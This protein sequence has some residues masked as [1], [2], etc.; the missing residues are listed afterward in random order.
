MKRI[1]FLCVLLAL[2]LCAECALGA[3]T[4]LRVFT[5]FADMD[6]AA[7]RYMDMITAWEEE[8]GNVVEDYS[9][10]MDDAWLD[11]MLSMARVGAADVVVLPM[12][13]GLSQEELVTVDELLAATD[14][15]G[16]RRFAALTEEDGSVLLS[17]VRVS[18][19]ALYINTDVLEANGLSVPGTYE[20]LL[21]VCGALAG[22]GVTPMANALCEWAEI[23]LDCAALVS[24]QPE[25]FGTQESLDGAQRMVAALHAV[26]AFGKDAFNATD[27]DTTAAFL[28]GE[29]AMRI[30]G[31]ALAQEIPADRR[32][33]V[34]VIPMPQPAGQ[35]HSV[36]PGTV[37]CGVAITRACWQDDARCEAALSLVRTML[38]AENLQGLAVG[39]DGA[40][41]ES[42]ANM[43]GEATDCAGILYDC[44]ETD[45]DA[46]QESVV[47][48]L[49]TK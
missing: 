29:A 39:V 19:E 41:G 23:V 17:P 35:A 11:M 24:T 21:A 46:W 3:G 26:G 9:G 1:G 16:V 44:A 38:G 36:L 8:T 42:I 32:D 30:D 18:W 49:M 45:F 6:A 4:T 31:D 7:Q 25:A 40:L 37:S 14:N 33:S 27:A 22:K 48:S 12:G 10:L 28:A 43:L 2:T 13:T 20:E 15:L 47:S 5:P 34:I